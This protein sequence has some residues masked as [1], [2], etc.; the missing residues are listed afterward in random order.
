MDEWRL[1]V[2]L[3]ALFASVLKVV[4]TL[5]IFT[6]HYDPHSHAIKLVR[7]QKNKGKL[8]MR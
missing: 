1:P 2:A 3:P 5:L 8:L 6:R 4:L 7:H